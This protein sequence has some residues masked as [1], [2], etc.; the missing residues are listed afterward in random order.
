[1]A[2]LPTAQ[3]LKEILDELKK[4]NQKLDL[5]REG[6]RVDVKGKDADRQDM[7]PQLEAAV[8]A[9]STKATEGD[10]KEEE[11]A[12]GIGDMEASQALMSGGLGAGESRNP[13]G[14]HRS[15]EGAGDEMDMP[16]SK[17]SQPLG[18][19][20]PNNPV[21]CESGVKE[22][23]TKGEKEVA[24]RYHWNL[25]AYGG[26]DEDYPEPS[27]D[28]KNKWT[29]L[30][31]HNWGIPD[32]GRQPLTLRTRHLM[33]VGNDV[34]DRTLQ[35]AQDYI[36]RLR[37]N[38]TAYSRFTIDDYLGLDGPR[39][40]YFGPEWKNIALPNEE[41][42]LKLDVDRYL[43]LDDTKIPPAPWRRFM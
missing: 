40:G 35:T 16:A 25:P 22:S 24:F 14:D 43:Q 7:I 23:S 36:K 27:E 33:Y 18:E 32:D 3:I 30:L 17:P 8:Q 38:G 28:Q 12:H 29:E 13:D 1:M 19:S 20:D 10:M 4:L 41:V 34:A 42:R 26:E 39:R 11:A 9:L 5:D 37:D 15:A 31:Q 2:E 6:R 21:S